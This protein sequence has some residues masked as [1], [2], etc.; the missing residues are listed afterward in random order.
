MVHE[1]A[2]QQSRLPEELLILIAPTLLEKLFFVLPVFRLKAK[3]R[4]P[5]KR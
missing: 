1:H 3:K 2:L 4:S 5:S